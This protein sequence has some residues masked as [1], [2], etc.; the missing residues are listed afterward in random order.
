MTVYVLLAGYEY[1][2]HQCLGV[3]DCREA[4]QIAFEA[5][6][7]EVAFGGYCVIE[8]RLVGALPEALY[9]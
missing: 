4:A 9:D 8:E 6:E 1:E 7:A 3:Y 5:A 2:G